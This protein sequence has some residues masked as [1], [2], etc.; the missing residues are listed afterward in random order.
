MPATVQ[1]VH[2]PVDTVLRLV[3]TVD[4]SMPNG[5]HWWDVKVDALTGQE[6]D[7]VDRIIRCAFDGDHSDHVQHDPTAPVREDDEDLAM[8]A[9]PNSYRVYAPP[10]ESLNHGNRSV[11]TLL[12]LAG[13]IASPY[14]WHDTNGAS[15][16]HITQR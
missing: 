8:P 1:L 9:G 3:W 4:F 14:G 6:L 2:W 15:G 16:V 13:G 7:Q 12:R 10:V 5:E 11:V